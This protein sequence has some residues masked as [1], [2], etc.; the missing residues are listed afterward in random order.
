MSEGLIW[1]VDE[2]PKKP[3]YA[4]AFDGTLVPAVLDR[5]NCGGVPVF[6]RES[7]MS[8]RC[9]NKCWAVIGSIGQPQ[10]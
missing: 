1:L 4:H 2:Q 9:D 5:M 3:V 7:D 10:S 8:Y 6:D